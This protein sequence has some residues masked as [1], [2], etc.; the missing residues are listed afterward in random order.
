MSCL[1]LWKESEPESDLKYIVSAPGPVVIDVLNYSQPDKTSVMS[2]SGSLPIFPLAG[3]HPSVSVKNS[4]NDFA[5]P[6]PFKFKWK[7]KKDK[8]K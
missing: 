8:T 5:G 1:T 7:E 3:C 6:V 2:S 4:H